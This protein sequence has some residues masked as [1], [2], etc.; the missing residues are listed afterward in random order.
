MLVRAMQLTPF[1]KVTEKE[2]GPGAL[3]VPIRNSNKPS[4]LAMMPPQSGETQ[5]STVNRVNDWFLLEAKRWSSP[6]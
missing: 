5:A 2:A 4:L 3:T 6:S 1:A